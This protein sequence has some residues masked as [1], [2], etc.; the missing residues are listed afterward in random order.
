MKKK[1]HLAMLLSIASM[2]AAHATDWVTTYTDYFGTPVGSITFDDWGY[3]GPDGRDAG[4]FEATNGFG[5]NALDPTGGIGQIQHVV[6]KDPDWITPDSSQTI[7]EDGI[8]NT[9]VFP[10]ANMDA[11]TN[12]YTWGYTTP[13]GSSF[14]N[15]QI[16]YDGDYHVAQSDMSFQF[17]S[18]LDHKV[19]D[20]DPVRSNTHFA[21]Q[22]YVLSDAKGWCGSVTGSHPNANEPMA[23]QLTFDIAFDVYFQDP[24]SGVLS[25]SSTEVIR[26]FEMR[27][28]GDITVDVPT[29]GGVAQ[30]FTSRAVVNNTNP[31]TIGDV[32]NP[33]VDTLVA[34]PDYHNEVSFHGAGVIGSDS[35]CG[36]ESAE[37]VAGQRGPGITRFSTY[38]DVANSAS[39]ATAGGTWSSNAFGSFAFLLRADGTRYLDYFDESVYGADPTVTTVP[40][41]AAFWLFGSGLVGL[42]GFARRKH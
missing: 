11:T 4:T 10:D 5:N 29:N 32:V 24:E 38:L 36:V 13:G 12:F 35:T 30:Q 34:D 14:N 20:A 19:G 27:S 6:T 40:V 15:M 41:P 31:G 42:I 39:C 9:G 22:P 21:F 25:F 3:T 23:G 7:L 17:M 16:D 8:N 33:D 28:W 1:L 18:Y 26:D 37:W 2:N